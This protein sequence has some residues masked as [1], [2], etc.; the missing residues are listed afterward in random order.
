VNQQLS[1]EPLP[2]SKLKINKD[3]K[4]LEDLEKLE[5]EDFELLNYKS[6]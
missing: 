3:L 6:H 5:W 2:L 4:T 1:N